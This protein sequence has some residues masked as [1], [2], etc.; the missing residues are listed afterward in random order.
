MHTVDLKYDGERTILG[1]EVS[2]VGAGAAVDVILI[3]FGSTVAHRNM[4]IKLV[5]PTIVMVNMAANRRNKWMS[6]KRL[7]I[8]MTL[9]EKY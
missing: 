4:S 1:I 6:L 7:L 8:L 9:S 2:V 5:S 3:V